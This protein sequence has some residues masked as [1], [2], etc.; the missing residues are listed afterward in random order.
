M[1]HSIRHDRRAFLRNL[2]AVLAGGAAFSLLPQLELVGR[3]IAASGTGDG[4]RAL[5]CI[6]LYGGNDSFNM[7]I[8]Y[9]NA[10]YNIYDTSRGGVYDPN[11]NPFGLGIARD[12]LAQITDTQ[13]KQWGLHPACTEMQP[14]FNSGELAFIANVGPLIEPVTKSDVVNGRKPLPPYLYS[15]GDQQPQWMRGYSGST[16]ATTGWGGLTADSISTLN[17]GGLAGLPPS[18]T[19]DGNNQFELGELTLQY[20]L[21]TSGPETLD[22]FRNDIGRGGDQTRRDALEAL[23]Q[24]QYTPVMQDQYGVVGESA[25]FLNDALG[26]ALDP[27]NDGDITTVFPP[28]YFASQLRM[29]A[30]MIKASQTPAL[31]QCRQIYF[32]GLGGFDTHTAQMSDQYGHAEYLGQLSGALSAFRAALAEIGAL[33]DVATFTMSDFGR[34]LNSNGDG[35]DHAWGSVQLVMGGATAN[36]GSLQGGQVWGSYPL[37]EL[38]G[39]QTLSRGEMIPT[40]SVQQMGS[41]LSY[42]LGA[43]D[44]DNSVIFPGIENF[45]PQR[46]GFLG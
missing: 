8:P 38:D 18:I 33:N 27:N 39:A 41:A 4:Y 34:T 20:A 11:S 44:S 25:L 29:I 22:R 46:L 5:V 23:I 10:E 26:T 17:A 36:G 3:A 45:S 37:L 15:H 31:G 28:T 42:W 19:L 40:T 30:R 9:D 35:T 13:G 2:Q 32:A 16:F 12:Q 14:L 21:S 43:T 6:F 7:L 24:A 1:S